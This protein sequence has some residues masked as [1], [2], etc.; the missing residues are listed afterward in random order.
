MSAKAYRIRELD[1]SVEQ[2]PDS[3]EARFERASLLREQGSFEEAKR[4]YLE[5][6]RRA[7]GHFG[8]LNDFG[9]LLLKAG[10]KDAA[11]TVFGEAIRHHPGNPMGH[12][13]LANL[14][15]W[16][17]EPAQARHHFEAALRID[18]DH[19]HAHRGMGNLLAAIGDETGARRHFDKGFQNHFL[20][21]LP[22]RG[23]RAAVSVLLLVS[24][25]GGN[26][27][28]NTIL[29]DRIFET[30]VLVTEYAEPGVSLPSHDLVFN[31]IGDA[32][33]CREGLQAACS[34]VARTGRPVINHPSAVLNTGRMSNAE[35]LRSIPGVRTPRMAAL[36]RA[37]LSG[38]DAPAIVEAHGFAF[39]LL[40]RAPGFHTGQHFVRVEGRQDLAEAAAAMPAENLW[41]IEQLDARGE[42]GKFRKCRAMVVDGRLYPLH[43]A[44]SGNWKVH[45]FRAEMA[46]SAE[47]RA[48]DAAFLDNMSGAVGARG[49][50]ALEQICKALAL[51]YGGIDFAVDRNGDILLFEAN[52]TMVMIPLSADPKW[53][54]RR[55]AF[56]RVFAA[57]QAML[58]AKSAAAASAPA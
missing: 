45:Y 15:F 13:N 24:A 47:H 7:P 40:L 44:I 26:I 20:T 39:P 58:M 34:I 30:T 43:L 1:W 28:T 17:D 48:Q 53:D 51:D 38:S 32:D 9:T 57:V 25:F 23:E 5:L 4:D 50:A 19:V 37:L 2:N 14:L 35:R 52:A 55:P 46:D 56:A 41:V 3:I 54:Y 22:Y 16:I 29:D 49:M 36:P 31:S 18:P 6:L 8:A 27:P 33:L 42:D 10:F 11:R 12:V 21:K